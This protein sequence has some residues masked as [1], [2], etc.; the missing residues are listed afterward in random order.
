MITETPYD[1]M[2]KEGDW[3]WVNREACGDGASLWYCGSESEPITVISGIDSN[4][5]AACL[6]K[7]ALDLMQLADAVAK[8]Q[9]QQP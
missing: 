1:T 3:C 4:A 9:Q 8:L 6:R 7:L 5:D 2:L